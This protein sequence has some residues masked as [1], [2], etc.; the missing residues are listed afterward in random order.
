MYLYVNKLFYFNRT[1]FHF[2]LIYFIL[3][4]VYPNFTNNQM[5]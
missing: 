3:F 5:K 2:Y 1:E 4:N